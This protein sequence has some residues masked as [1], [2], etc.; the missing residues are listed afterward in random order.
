L[1]RALV[2]VAALSIGI[3]VPELSVFS[4]WIQWILCAMLF[5]GFSAVPLSGFRPE[6]AHL[7]LLLAWPLFA[8]A[9][10]FLLWPVGPQA[11]AAGFLVG[12]TPTATAAPVVVGLLGGD[13]AFA[14]VSLL[15]SNL[16]AALVL[17]LVLPALGADRIPSTLPFAARTLAVVLVPLALA[18]VARRLPRSGPVL[19]RARAASFPLWTLALLLAAAKSSASLRRSGIGVG[20]IAWIAAGSALLCACHFLS[21]R[22]LGG[23]ERSLEAS[24]SLGQKNTLLT[25]WMGLVAFGPVAALGPTTYVLWHNLWNAFQL[26]RKGRVR[27]G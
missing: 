23:R 15:G 19:A 1:I 18:A 7:R 5:L 4:A 22:F 14:T 27:A 10:W 16:V 3:L 12:A 21:G 2:V 20:V 17:P 8:V 13:A 26:A 6:R 9:G 11:R 25:I 24:Q